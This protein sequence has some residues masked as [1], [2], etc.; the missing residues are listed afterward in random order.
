MLGKLMKYEFRATA[1]VFVPL[2]LVVVMLGL[3]ASFS[4]GM[5]TNQSA[6]LQVLGVVFIMLFVVSLYALVL[7]SVILMLVRFYRNLMTDEG[8]LMFTLPVRTSQLIFSKLL[9]SLVWFVGAAVVAVLA[10]YPMTVHPIITGEFNGTSVLKTVIENFGALLPRDAD[11][12]ALLIVEGVSLTILAVV[13]FCLMSYAA[14]SVGQS[15]RKNK[16]LLSIVFFFV[17]NA[18]SQMIYQTL[19]VIMTAKLKYRVITNALMTQSVQQ[20]LIGSIIVS[21][22]LGVGFYFLTHYMLQRRLNLQ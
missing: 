9:V 3:V 20:V 17:F 15:F 2:Y 7:L 18:V 10:L 14:I 5:T 13:A 1:R 12:R 11:T 22:L 21:V 16:V 4:L 6:F 8:Y 19:L